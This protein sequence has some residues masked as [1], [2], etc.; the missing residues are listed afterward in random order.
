MKNQDYIQA[1]QE[2]LLYTYERLPVAFDH[3]LGSRLWD[4]E[5]EEYVDMVAGIAVC[6]LGHAHPQLNQALA[7]QAGK[8]WHT[9]NLFWIP[10]QVEAAQL[11]KQISGLDKVFFCNSGTEAN[12]AALKLARKYFYRLGQQQKTEII[13]FKQSFHGRTLGS[14]TATG[15]PKYHEGFAPLPGGFAYADYNN[16]ASVEAL[17]TPQTAAVIMEPIQGESGIFPAEPE[18]MQGIYELCQEHDIL[19]IFD[20]VQCGVGRTG[21]FFAFENYGIKPDI[22]TMAK[23]LAGGFPIGAIVANAKVAAGFKPGDHAATF[24]GNPLGTA[25]AKRLIELVNTPDVL[26][27]VSEQGSYLQEQ[28]MN[29]FKGDARFHE[30][31]G[32][33][34]MLGI[35]FH[36]PVGGLIKLAFRHKLLVAGAG[37]KTVRLGPPLTLSRADADQ[38]LERLQ[39]AW[40]EWK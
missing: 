14:L 38:A 36:E 21:K 9:S 26:R 16:L 18:F 2:S 31:R 8:V 40:R 32:R 25:V 12:E 28:L 34:L 7:E 10:R 4:V 35:G 27:N 30:I 6:A 20:E 23:G 24:G 19:L 33:G 22:V 39:A 37:G 11:L 13:A 3:G 17:I 5:G 29:I 1:G 15:Q